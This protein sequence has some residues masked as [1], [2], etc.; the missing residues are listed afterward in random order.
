MQ[1]NYFSIAVLSLCFLVMLFIPLAGSSQTGKGSISG[2]VT[3]AAGSV[4][5]GARIELT[6]SAGSVVSD[7]Q[8][9]FVVPNL[10]PGSYQV[11]ITFVGFAPF[12]KT[13]AVVAGQP[14]RLDAI[15]QVASATQEILVTATDVH[16]DAEA[17]NRIDTS[18]NILN[19]I[20]NDQIMSLPNADVADALGRML[21]VTLER[22]EGEG[23][24]V[25]I[26][27]TEPRLSNTTIDGVLAPSP[28]S[29]VNQIKLDT[30]PA[31]LV[32][33][34][35]INKTLS[36]NQD[37]DAIGGSVNL[38]TKTAG[39]TPTI[40]AFGNGG[41]TP[42]ID[43]RHA[44]Q[45][46]ITAG[47]RYLGKK[48][49]ILGNYTYDYNGRGID[50]IEPQPDPGTLTPS[51]DSIDLRE[52]RYDRTRW[53]A[54]TSIDYKLSEGSLLY[55]K[56]FYSDFKDYG[57]KWVYTLN[58]NVSPA[59][60]PTGDPATYSGDVPKYSTSKRSPDY[61]LGLL[62]IGGNHLFTNSWFKW[63]TAV[64]R[65]RQL[66]AAGNP[67]AKFKVTKSH[68][69][70]SFWGDNCAYDPG[71]NPSEYRPQWQAACTASGAETF[72]PSVYQLSELD[73]TSGQ[74]TQI[75]LQGSAAY[76]FNYHVGSHFS[77]FEMGAKVRNQHKGQFAYSPT[78]DN[79]PGG[80]LMS[81]F[82]SPIHN[83]NYYDKS[84]NMGPL[85]D[86]DSIVAFAKTNPSL[87]PLDVDATRIGSDASNFNL[88]QRITAGY[89]MNTT[90]FGKLHVQAGLRFEAT[91][92]STTGY[93][94]TTNPDGSWGGTTPV[95]S[96]KSYLDVLPSAQA[97][98]AITNNSD[99]RA[100]Y[101]RGIARP[102]PQDIIPYI[103]LDTS[104]SP[105][106]LGIG[107]PALVPEH[108][109]DFDVL[110]E[111]YLTPLGLV[112]AGFFYKS[113]SDPLTQET[114]ILSSGTYAGFKQSQPTNGGTAWVYGVEIGYQQRLSF[115]PGVLGGLGFAGNYTYSDSQAKGVDPLRTDS[116][117]LLRQTPHTW[118][119]GPSYDRGRVSVHMGFE[120]NGASIYA[121]QY[122]NLAYA[123]DA[124]G[125]FIYNANGTLQTVANPQVGNTAGPAGD[126]YLYAHLQVDAQVSYRL[127]KGFEVYGQG[128]NL[129]NEVF[130]FY[131]GSP[132][133]VVQREY[134]QPTYGGGLRWTS[135]HE[136]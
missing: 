50:D 14:A 8:G 97:R 32:E 82:L 73:L 4:L 108:A 87:F 19:V 70:D 21:G 7:I 16:G 76:A 111:H 80:I 81:Q 114:R 66:A 23:K 27:G 28:E 31:D 113:L 72:D 13:V 53:G 136:K 121:Y 90:Q 17:I 69:K 88:E 134:Y 60:T 129:T 79:E 49:G 84:Y 2:R 119:L 91:N 85:T 115:L 15:M 98:Y 93:Q 109:N 64:S 1:K 43:G 36:A 54:A 78:Y 96:S 128:L 40:T 56:T 95:K 41:Y 37:G 75:N 104:Q 100:S 33:S 127:P 102:D 68:K 120:Y 45:F 30:I 135:H 18:E 42:I 118:N 103:T 10:V 106:L 44:S 25:Q 47:K 34:V 71:A 3:D 39:D 105:S 35:E 117:A 130:G 20:T 122:E 29:T 67:G 57:D 11:S 133:Y 112:Q 99:V 77:T 124:N 74:T 52:Y 58:D 132:Q 12:S 48:L 24:Y 46:G 22:D 94:V 59:S 6:P 126:N 86:Y 65:A 55:A 51:Y 131:N 38:V 116:P 62:T 63:E 107:N 61:G 125:N 123:T 9:E 92:L 83:N 26:R 101:G 110:Y 5:Q 89:V